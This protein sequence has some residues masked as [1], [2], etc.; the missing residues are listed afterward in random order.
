MRDKKDVENFRDYLRGWREI[1]D[2][3]RATEIRLSTD[4][5][6]TRLMHV[7]KDANMPS[8]AELEAAYTAGE[9]PFNDLVAAGGDLDSG[10]IVVALDCF[11]KK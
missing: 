4:P 8:D 5:E 7:L 11:R 2:A 9:W 1:E 3:K 10:A 6:H